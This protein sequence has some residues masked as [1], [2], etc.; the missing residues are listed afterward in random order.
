M[1][2][3]LFDLD[4]TLLDTSEG[5]IKSAQYAIRQLGYNP[6]SRSIMKTFIGPPI[7]DS[8]K[9]YYHCNDETAQK[10]ANIFRDYYLKHAT[11][12]ATVYPGIYDT[13]NTLRRRGYKIAVAT[14]KREDI[15]IVMLDKFNIK[16]YCDVIH[17]ADNFNKLSKSDVINICLEEL[18]IARDSVVL[19]G[20]SLHDANG[21][22]E[23]KISF[24][25]ALY[26]LGLK[27]EKDILNY[28]CLGCI[29]SPSELLDYI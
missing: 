19:V 15:A 10:G 11:G 13:L 16:K 18:N 2:A 4:G 20:D 23:A 26:G 27:S 17:G 25:A 3:V 5:V 12:I 22:L 29:S 14:Y 1:K 7:Q 24:I 21:A 28:P 8:L 9:K 6:L